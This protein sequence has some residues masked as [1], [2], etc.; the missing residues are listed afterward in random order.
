MN[1]TVPLS[2]LLVNKDKSENLKAS[3][4]QS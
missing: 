1:L 3:W 2:S 4:G